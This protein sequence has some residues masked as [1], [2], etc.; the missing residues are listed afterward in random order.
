MDIRETFLDRA[1]AI[2][3]EENVV[4]VAGDAGYKDPYPLN[5]GRSKWPGIRPGSVEEVQNLVRLANDAGV[6]LWTFSRG[7]NLGYGGPEPRDQTMVALDLGRMNRILEV[8]DKLCY[9][10]VEPGVTFFDLFEYIQERGLK[11]WLSVPA[12]GWGSVMGNMLDRGYGM[13]PYGDHVKSLCGME[14]VLPDGDLV[15]TGMGAMEGTDLGPIFQGGFGPTLDGLFTQS[16]L[17]V[18]TKVGLW[19]MPWPDVY[20][21]GDVTAEREEDLPQLI[22]ILTD[23]RRQDVIQNN[24]LCG[25]VVRA[26]TMRGSKADFY[27]GEGSIPDE[28]LEEMRQEFGIGQWNA[29]FA[30][31]G[32]KGLAERRLEIIRE[33]FAGL[34]GVEVKARLYEGAEGQAVAYEDITEIDRTQMAGVPTLKPLSTVGWAAENGG[35]IDAAPII[36]ARGHEVYEFY[37]EAKQLYR[38]YGFD[39][40]IGYHLYPRHMVHVTMIFFENDNEEMLA[41]ARE[42][43]GRLLD[44]ARRRGYAPYRSH[45]DYMDRIAEGFDFNNHAARR[46]QEKLKDVLDPNGVISP[47]KQGVW[48]ARL[49]A[50]RSAVQPELAPAQI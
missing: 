36:P 30:I 7:K 22:D 48:P 16:N 13:T 6:A 41:R 2:V 21:S 5:P 31:Y 44:A 23:L 35:H 46:L 20:I 47:G 15:R 37:Q 26:A 29:R 8:D 42:L 17:G 11:V 38:E 33:R 25:N 32:D 1:A 19:L 43:Y 27:D 10:V 50:Q 9:A 18:V 28:R 12:L 14:V 49:R 24:A 34:E 4:R 3:G 40:Y 45:V 39:L